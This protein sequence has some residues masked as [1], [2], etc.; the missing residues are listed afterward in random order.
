M[1]LARSMHGY[2]SLLCLSKDVGQRCAAA[3]GFAQGSRG[4]AHPAP[5]TV[6]PSRAQPPAPC[7]AQWMLC[8]ALTTWARFYHVAI[9]PTWTVFKLHLIVGCAVITI[10][11]RLDLFGLFSLDYQIKVYLISPSFEWLVTIYF[12]EDK[13]LLLKWGNVWVFPLVFGVPWGWPSRQ[14]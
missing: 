11:G 3:G 14:G 6:L 1:A 4:T 7:D 8:A 2:I 13:H 9:P 10:L 12:W 5:S